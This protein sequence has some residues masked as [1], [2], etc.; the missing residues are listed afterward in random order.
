V[1]ISIL[2]YLI[3]NRF[4]RFV[5]LIFL[6]STGFLVAE[7]ETR[8][9]FRTAAFVPASHLFRQIYGRARV[10]YQL[11]AAF[12]IRKYLE[13]WSNLDWFSKSGRSVGCRYRTTVKIGNFSFGANFI[14]P[15][16]RFAF[17][18]GVGPT[19]GGIWLKNKPPHDHTSTS[20]AVF[21]GVAKAG[22]YCTVVDLVYLDLFADYLYQPVH[23]ERHINV[24]GFKPGIGIGVEF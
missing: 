19:F 13:I 20:K 3:I 9:E 18:V 10:D 8:L 4:V 12:D 22:I 21:G 11:Q 14:Y 7:T 5:F 1:N 24:G 15:F 6:F 23:F 17:Y 16:N 2:W